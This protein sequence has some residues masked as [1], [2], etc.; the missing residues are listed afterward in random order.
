MKWLFAVAAFVVTL[1]IV[2]DNQISF[3]QS[4]EDFKT[5]YQSAQKDFNN[6]V[7]G[8]Y[9]ADVNSKARPK[10][11]SSNNDKNSTIA[12]ADTKIIAQKQVNKGEKVYKDNFDRSFEEFDKDFDKKW[13]NF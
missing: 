11:M 7:D 6:A 2:G 8:F 12:K 9:K 3:Q 4:K 5:G 10:K 13:K 1:I